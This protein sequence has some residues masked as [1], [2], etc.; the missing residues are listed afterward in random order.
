MRGAVIGRVRASRSAELPEGAYA[1][2]TAGWT[3]LAVVTEKDAERVDIPPE[4]KATDALGVLGGFHFLVLW[5]GSC[6]A[7]LK[8]SRRCAGMGAARG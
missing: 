4:G 6:W 8:S 1:V 2:A 7:G 5:G 3:E